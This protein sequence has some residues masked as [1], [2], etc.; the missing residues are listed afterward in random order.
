M[1][2]MYHMFVLVCHPRALGQMRHF[3]LL[4]LACYVSESLIVQP[5]EREME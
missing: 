3:Q 5:V 2:R 1:P 4:L